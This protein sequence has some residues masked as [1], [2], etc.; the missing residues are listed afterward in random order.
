MREIDFSEDNLGNR[1]LGVKGIWNLMQGEVKRLV[2]VGL[3]RVLV[4]EQGARVGCR[5]YKRSKARRGY[6]NG[7][8][9]RDLLTSYGWIEGLLVPRV[10]E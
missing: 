1:W 6:R 3:E 9:V 7:S 10:R 2:K 5:R 4:F 8:Y